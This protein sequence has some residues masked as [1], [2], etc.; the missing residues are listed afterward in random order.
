MALVS[1][2]V[3]AQPE[4]TIRRSRLLFP[5]GLRIQSPKIDRVLA[6]AA[7]Q[8]ARTAGPGWPG[9]LGCSEAQPQPGAG[10]RP[11]D[12]GLAADRNRAGGSAGDRPARLARD[13]ARGLRREPADRPDAGR[14]RGAPRRHHAASAG[15]RRAASQAGFVTPA[16]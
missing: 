12:P 8:E 10:P 4:T 15:V 16:G 5:A 6:A 11:G 9:V 2:S 14:R 13:P 1:V 7:D 3:M